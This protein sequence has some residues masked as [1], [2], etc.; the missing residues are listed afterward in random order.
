[1]LF[2]VSVP[3]HSVLSISCVHLHMR[4]PDLQTHKDTK[5]P[6]AYTWLFF[7]SAF[8]NSLYFNFYSG[9][10][11]QGDYFAWCFNEPLVG[12]NYVAICLSVHY[13]PVWLTND[14]HSSKIYFTGLYLRTHFE[15]TL[16]MNTA[17][18]FHYILLIYVSKCNSYCHFVADMKTYASL[19]P[20]P[21][22][23]SQAWASFHTNSL[24]SVFWSVMAHFQRFLF[25]LFL[26]TNIKHWTS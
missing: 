12:L 3:F 1:M 16:N 10:K 7:T 6:F 24:W 20:F 22:P 19:Y 18:T 4:R 15:I 5:N 25:S 9:T 14:W 23:W 11:L 26:H 2:I 13:N 8:Y 21:N 17:S